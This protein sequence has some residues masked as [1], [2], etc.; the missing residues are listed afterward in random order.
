MGPTNHAIG[1][2]LAVE[3]IQRLRAEGA[4]GGPRVRRRRQP[5][6]IAGMARTA[7]AEP[8]LLRAEGR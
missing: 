3:R 2:E 7:S 4:G 8:R 5:P 6:R 1:R